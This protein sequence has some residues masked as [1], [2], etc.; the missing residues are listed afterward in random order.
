MSAYDHDFQFLLG[1]LGY[2]LQ[3]DISG[4]CEG[5]K[6]Y[7]LFG[8]TLAIKLFNHLLSLRQ[9]AEGVSVSI[10]DRSTYLSDHGSVKL[11]AR[12]ALETL[13]VFHYIYIASQ[14]IEERSLRFRLW[15]LGGLLDRQKTHP[16]SQEARNVIAKERGLIQVLQQQIQQFPKF[17]KFKP[18]IQKRLLNGEWQGGKSW[19]DLASSANFNK[20][21]FRN[22][23]GYLCGY[24]HT[25]YLSALQIQQANEIPTQQKMSDS[26]L[27]VGLVVLSHFLFG[28][29]SLFSKV[30][31][32]FNAD[33]ECRNTAEKWCF[34]EEDMA[35][36]YGS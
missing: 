32:S 5:E 2:Y 34:R 21:Y 9:L 6:R 36:M 16:I 24:A 12:A 15:E 26:T 28:Y 4:E 31:A 23:Y 13:L 1:K 11:L 18:R 8:E 25:S 22:V 14:D 27:G 7:L 35:E 30:G 19:A 20:K 10:D 29:A 17:A 33:G 3:L